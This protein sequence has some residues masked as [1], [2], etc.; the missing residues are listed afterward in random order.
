MKKCGYILVVLEKYEHIWISIVN[1][2][3]L[4]HINVHNQPIQCIILFVLTDS[5]CVQRFPAENA[6]IPC[7]SFIC[8]TMGNR[9]GQHEHPIRLLLV[10]Q[11]RAGD[12]ASLILYLWY[13]EDNLEDSYWKSRPWASPF[14]TGS[15]PGL[16]GW[17]ARNL[18]WSQ[19]GLNSIRLYAIR[20]EW[21][22]C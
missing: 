20:R 13:Y 11:L 9:R 12:R 1:L 7:V 4:S 18:M 19:F 17:E 8:S 2:G 5:V 14:M 6:H 21:N 22:V 15:Q 3:L 16:C 10:P